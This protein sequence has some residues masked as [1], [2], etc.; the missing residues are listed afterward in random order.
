MKRYAWTILAILVL[1]LPALA[2]CGPAPTPEKVIVKETVVSVQTA[3]TTVK[4]TVVVK[5]TAV[6]SAFDSADRAV[7][8]AKKYA[9]I[10]LNYVREAG[11]QAQDPLFMGPIF[12][13]LTGIKINTVEMSYL[14]MYTNQ[15]QDHLTGGGAYD[16]LDVSPFWTLDYLNAGVLE[17]LDDY[18]A[19]YMNPADLEDYL[20]VY[21]AEGVMQF[22]GKYYGLY[23]DG[24]VFVQYY[25]KDL[26]EDEKNKAEFKAKYGYD[27]V[28]PKTGKELYDSAEFF[29]NKFKPDLYGLAIQRLE[30]QD[31]SWF[32]GPYAAYGGYLWDPATM[33]A[34]ING[35]VGVKTLTE[36]VQQNK[37]MPPGVEKWG[38]MEVLSAWMDG[39]VAMII[40]WPPIG[41]WSAGYGDT[42]KQLSWV[43]P[44]KVIGKV[45][46]QLQ[47]GGRPTLAGGF[48]LCLSADSKHKEA[49]YLFM[50]WM[51]SPK[52]SLQRVML[53]FA[54][55]DPY[56]MTHFDSALYRSAWPEAGEY[57][58]ALKQASTGVWEPGVPGGREYMEAL[59]KA[60]TAAYAGKDV[61]AVLD[62]CAKRWDEITNRLGV[63]AQKAA[64]N[65]WLKNPNAQPGATVK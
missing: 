9:G 52:I 3:V 33:K 65:Q 51:T 23:D 28:P 14:D 58:D 22:D 53:P 6:P 41:R 64:Y 38:F 13:Q 42:A 50:Q 16:V 15:L 45:G 31:Y 57:L 4:E 61:K 1:V 30:G 2:A 36:M 49:A 32:I 54:L 44:S 56:R 21:K 59:D 43:P 12:E 10:T 24:D 34:Q 8:E 37:V 29:T 25:R 48:N 47:Y 18:I 63:D 7:A 40:T 17:P 26:F 19:K 60:I 20:P 27:L 39:K 55:R 5:E 46:Y 62:D 35:D 11:L